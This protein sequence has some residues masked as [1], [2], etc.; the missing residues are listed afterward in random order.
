M[1]VSLKEITLRS[2]ITGNQLAENFNRLILFSKFSF[3][4]VEPEMQLK[5]AR[6]RESQRSADW[7]RIQSHVSNSEGS[8]K[9]REIDVMTHICT[10][11]CPRCGSTATKVKPQERFKCESC[12]WQL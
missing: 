11:K 9:P 12:G 8:Q 1:T 4:V 7:A 3:G 10:M 2:G 5:I 6:A